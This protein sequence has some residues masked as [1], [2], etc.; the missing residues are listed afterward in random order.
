MNSLKAKWGITSVGQFWLIMLCFA[1]TGTTAALI[2]GPLLKWIGFPAETPWYFRIPLRLLIVLP[3][4]QVLLLV[5]G[6]LLGQFQFFWAFE[7]KMFRL[8]KRKKQNIERSAK[9][10]QE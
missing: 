1:L 9:D 5:Y 7:K 4:Y 10:N 2:S 6:W 8:E 3:I